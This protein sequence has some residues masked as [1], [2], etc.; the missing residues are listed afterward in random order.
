MNGRSGGNR[1][2]RGA[3]NRGEGASLATRCRDDPPPAAIA[4]SSIP[5]A[6]RRGRGARA[7]RGRSR[8]GHAG[9]GVAAGGDYHG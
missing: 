9:V 5:P 6:T 4:T 8:G 1:R 3:A 2:H 7:T